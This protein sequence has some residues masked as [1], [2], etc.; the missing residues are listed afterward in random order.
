[1]SSFL[2]FMICLTPKYIA[3]ATPSAA[4]MPPI[5][6]PTADAVLSPLSLWASASTRGVG[7][8]E[9]DVPFEDSEDDSEV[10]D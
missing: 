9:F 8:V 3:T 5:I 1:M 10:L 2:R 4:K 6:E 7:A